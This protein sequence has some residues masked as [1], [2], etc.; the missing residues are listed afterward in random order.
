MT[1]IK[2]LSCIYILEVLMAVRRTDYPGLGSLVA[3]GSLLRF[4]V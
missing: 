1:S 2:I 4:A 3:V